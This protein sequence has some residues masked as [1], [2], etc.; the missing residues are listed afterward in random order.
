M[1]TDFSQDAFFK[2]LDYLSDKNLVNSQ[3]VRAWR[4]AASRLMTDL[5]EAEKTDVRTIDHDL[6]VRRAV[7]RDSDSLSPQSLKTYQRRV[8][9]AIEEFVKRQSDPSGYKPRGLNEQSRIKPSGERTARQERMK[10]SSVMPTEKHE[11][12]T[13]LTSSDLTLSYPL[14]SDF[15]AQVV[16]PRDLNVM[17]AKRLGAFLLTI[18]VDYQPQ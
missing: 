3:T 7:N 9:I 4:S 5:S 17:E 13:S 15:L 14:R 18:A 2:F 16:I 10:P 8:E 6:T 11:R 12:E 1:N